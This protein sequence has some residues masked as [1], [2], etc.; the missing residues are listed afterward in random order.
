MNARDFTRYVSVGSVFLVVAILI[1]LPLGNILLS[2]V[3][4]SIAGTRHF[5]ADHFVKVLSGQRYWVAVANTLAIALMSTALA[6]GLGVS[7]AW[8][9]VRTNLPGAATLERLAI[10][11]IFIPPFV[12]AFAWLLLGAPRIGFFNKLTSTFGLGEPFDVYGHVGIAWVIGIYLAPY[13]LM[14]VASALRSMDPSLEEAAQ[15]AG[16][17]RTRTAFKITFPLVAPAILSGAILAFVIAIGLFG[18]PVMLGWARQILTITG[19]IYLESQEIPPAFGEM[20]VLAIYLMA[21]SVGAMGLQKLVLRGRSYITVTGKG[22]RPRVISFGRARY[23]M[24]AAALAYVVLTVV[25]PIAI[26]ALAAASTYTWS[27]T[28]TGQ[29]FTYLF[30]SQDVLQTLWNSL[31]IT[32][33]GATIATVLGVFVSWVTIRTRYS[34]RHV[35]EYV[36]LLPVSVPGIAFAVGVMFLWLPAPIPI[37]GTIWLIIIGLVGRFSA[38]AVRSISASLVQVHPELEE[39]ARIAGYGWSRTLWKITLPLVRPSIVASWLLLYSIFITELSMVVLL[40][41]TLSRTFS[42]LTFENW[43][44]GHFSRVASL[45]LLQ[46]AVGVSVMT[47]VHFFTRQKAH[48][49][50]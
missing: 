9:F 7:L 47:F 6:T 25:A 23:V 33:I 11:P 29:N 13:V 5:T 21:L 41:T 10:V 24:L 19:R 28:F 32:F 38:Y 20:A 26:I 1:V 50:S 16:L 2:S 42:I 49:A 8:I 37:Y 40:H 39:S 15:V 12:G 45:S 30:T 22:F 34:W 43:F 44:A 48:P 31:M 17:S 46:L 35:L 4:D 18:T 3:T 27:W 14:I 36:V